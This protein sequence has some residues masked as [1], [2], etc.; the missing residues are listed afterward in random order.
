MSPEAIRTSIR[1]VVETLNTDLRMFWYKTNYT[2]QEAV[3]IIEQIAECTHSL[4]CLIEVNHAHT[5][6]R[7][8]VVNA[9]VAIEILDMCI[10]KFHDGQTAIEF[11]ELAIGM[12]GKL[13]EGLVK[14][15]YQNVFRG[16]LHS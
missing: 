12:T 14:D 2:P 3:Y 15:N 4:L 11:A 5:E 16:L 1:N 7:S 10:G 13:L 6:F 9:D 8:R